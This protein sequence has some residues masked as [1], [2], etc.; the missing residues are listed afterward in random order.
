MPETKVQRRPPAPRAATSHK[1]PAAT[2]KRPAENGK[3]KQ[4]SAVDRTTELSDEVLKSLE[5]RP[6]RRDRCGAQVRRHRR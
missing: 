5:V 1:R 6:A 2:H 4:A 3:H